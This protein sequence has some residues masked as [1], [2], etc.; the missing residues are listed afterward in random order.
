MRN[1]EQRHADAV[2]SGLHY[3]ANDVAINAKRRERYATD[4]DYRARRLDEAR[5]ARRKG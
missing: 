5:R 3:V 2:R 1:A 4:P